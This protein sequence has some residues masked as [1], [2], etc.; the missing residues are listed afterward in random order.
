MNNTNKWF[1]VTGGPSSGKTSVLAELAK[2]GYKTIPEAARSVIDEAIAN[3]QSVE[4]LRADEK[5]FQELVTQRKAEIEA[6]LDPNETIFFDRG[7]HDTLAYLEAYDF[8][9]EAWVKELLRSSTY[10]QVF[11]LDPLPRYVDDY[12]RTENADFTAK[13]H[14][15]LLKAYE[16][17]GMKPL[18]VKVASPSER[19]QCIIDI[20]KEK[21]G[22]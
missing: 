7:M 2:Y 14:S 15:L 4:E 12:A 9:I 17:Y 16:A 22:E 11:L 21:A 10:A 13:V 20:V 8:E 19:A 6:V 18:S 3:G 1:V 5:N